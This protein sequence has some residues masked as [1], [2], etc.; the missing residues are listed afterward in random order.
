MELL[1]SYSIRFAQ[2]LATVA[3]APELKKFH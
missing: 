1:D 2:D 3:D